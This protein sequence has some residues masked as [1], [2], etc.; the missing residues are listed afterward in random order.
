MA[1]IRSD[2]PLVPSVLDR[3]IDERPDESREAPKTR[4]QDLRRSEAEL[5]AGP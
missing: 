4:G 2:Q 5:A 3:L 1:K